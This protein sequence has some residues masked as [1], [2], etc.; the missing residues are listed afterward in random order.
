[1]KF[2]RDEGGKRGGGGGWCRAWVTGIKIKISQF[3]GIKIDFSQITQNSVFDFICRPSSIAK[4]RYQLLC[5]HKKLF[6][7]PKIVNLQ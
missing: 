6:S 7:H 5:I 2:P 1:M 3:T 4:L